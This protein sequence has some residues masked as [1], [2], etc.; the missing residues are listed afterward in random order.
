MRRWC[1]SSVRAPL[2]ERP[3]GAAVLTAHLDDI[4]EAKR[5][6]RREPDLA[7]LPELYRLQERNRAA[8]DDSEG[9]R[10]A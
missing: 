10:P 9:R 2:R 4:I 8:S 3:G 6:L 5:S 1:R 7:A